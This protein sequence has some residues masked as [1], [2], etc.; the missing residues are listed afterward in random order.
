MTLQPLVPFLDLPQSQLI[1]LVVPSGSVSVAVIRAPT[2][3]RVGDSATAPSSSALSTS[4]VTS[5]SS[6]TFP[7]RATTV[8]SYLLSLSESAGDS[9]LGTLLKVSR[10]PLLM[11]KSDASV[12]PRLHLTLPALGPVALYSATVLPIVLLIPDDSAPQRHQPLPG[13][14]GTSSTSVTLIVTVICGSSGRVH[15][16]DGHPVALLRLVVQ[17]RPGWYTD[18]APLESIDW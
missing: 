18:L 15:G 4:T 7:E 1:W 3:T 12:P 5:S 2:L 16:L 17:L 14:V 11:E 8:I 13:Q 9:K 10:P 6:R